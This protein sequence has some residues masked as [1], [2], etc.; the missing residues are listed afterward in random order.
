[1]DIVIPIGIYCTL[2]LSYLLESCEVSVSKTQ[3][4]NKRYSIC[5]ENLPLGNLLETLFAGHIS[6]QRRNRL[7]NYYIFFIHANIYTK[8]SPLTFENIFE[9]IS[10]NLKWSSAE[11]VVVR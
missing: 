10:G 8:K 7:Q 5:H 11:I 2:V 4:V 6:L 1:M 9:N 3:S